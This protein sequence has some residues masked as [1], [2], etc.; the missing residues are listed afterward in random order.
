MQVEQRKTCLYYGQYF[1]LAQ[2]TY[3]AHIGSPQLQ[4]YEKVLLA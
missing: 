1:S 3:Q 2:L 4:E